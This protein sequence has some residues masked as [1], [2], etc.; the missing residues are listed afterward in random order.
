MMLDPI[1]F[2]NARVNKHLRKASQVEENDCVL[3][4]ADS[5][6]RFKLIMLT[7]SSVSSHQAPSCVHLLVA[8]N[9][10][11]NLMMM[12]IICISERRKLRSKVVGRWGKMSQLVGLAPSCGLESAQPSGS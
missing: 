11:S 4:R 10:H 8:F 9:S 6:I 7:V 12:T 3:R 1:A 2:R 5:I